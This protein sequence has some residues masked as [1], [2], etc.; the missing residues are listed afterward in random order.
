MLPF[1]SANQHWR[2]KFMSLDNPTCPKCNSC[3]VRLIQDSKDTDSYRCVVCYITFD[4]MEIAENDELRRFPSGATRS[5]DA[6]SERYDLISPHAAK[7]E[8]IV[9]AEGARTHGDRNWEKGIPNEVCLNHL[10]RHL[11]RYKMGDRSEDHLAK[12]RIGAGFLIHFEEV[13]KLENQTDSNDIN[14][15]ILR[16]TK[17]P[18]KPKKS[19]SPPEPL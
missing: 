4:P 9:M 16:P 18:K 15:D 2:F 19:N 13:A 8:S 12:I 3:N 10:E 5:V 6:D 14:L 7:R 17:K 1:T 11:I